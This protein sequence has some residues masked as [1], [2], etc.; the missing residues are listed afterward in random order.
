MKGSE[1]P[2]MTINITDW[3]TGENV[4]YAHLIDRRA[5][6]DETEVA[7]GPHTDVFIRGLTLDQVA[8]R[9]TAKL[10]EYVAELEKPEGGKQ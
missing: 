7:A 10:R 6:K 4:W 5:K 1:S 8:Q 3:V 2:A 9:L